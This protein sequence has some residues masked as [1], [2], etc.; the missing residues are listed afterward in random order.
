[1][2]PTNDT[3]LQ[4]DTAYDYFNQTLF[5]GRLPSCVMT[6][7]RKK[8]AYGYFW[9]D[10]WSE[11]DGEQ[12]TDEIALNPET[13]QQRSTPEV[14]STLVHEMCHLQ[15]FHFGKPSRNGYHNK[16]WAA[17]MTAVGLVPSATGQ[18]E[19]KTTGQKMSQYIA[20][21]G[22][23]AQACSALIDQGFSIPWQA[24]TRD[25]ATAKKKAASKTKYT[26]PDCGVNAWAK[27][28]TAL[29]CGDCEIPLEAADGGE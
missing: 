11:R 16:E 25:E 1:M 6:L 13:F 27:P 14:L 2:K 21:G 4:L 26:C 5:A 12:R 19:G 18:P 23:F 3:Y 20:E 22:A 15:Q 28:E 24:I 7:H 8:G 9:F 17:L 29:I 10:T